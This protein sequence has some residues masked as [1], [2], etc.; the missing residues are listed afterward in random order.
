MRVD[1]PNPPWKDLKPEPSAGG[2]LSYYYSDDLS[3]LP[4]RWVT[5]P[6]DNK[7]DPNLETCTYGLFSTCSP[8]MRS[9][10]VKRRVGFVFF[11]TRRGSEREVAGY[12][13]VR[14]HT[15]GPI[16]ANDSCVAADKC[17]FVAS[18]VPF[19]VV[20]RKLNTNF[21]TPFRSTRL[22]SET[23]CT[24]LVE[25]LREQ[26][27]AREV[28]L[29]EIDRLERFNLKHGDYRYISWKQVQKFDWP[30]AEKYLI[31]SSASSGV[32]APNASPS[33]LWRCS[34]CQQ[35]V[36]NKALLKRCPACGN[37]GTLQPI[38]S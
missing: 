28:Y 31:P 19:S 25:L 15:N 18:P 3:R 12:Y 13:Q 24:R 34:H 35:K 38:N 4:V 1:P 37:L 9:G 2:Y 30:Y 16:G 27:N 26:P 22:L 11:F 6:G 17:H 33:G 5:K 10:I 36:K 32:R 8:A 23:E 21:S 29:A 14:W 7:S 20:D